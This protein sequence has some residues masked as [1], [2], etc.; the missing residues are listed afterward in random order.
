MRS[1]SLRSLKCMWLPRSL[2]KTR[3][4]P[5]VTI[6]R[7]LKPEK[8][9]VM[10][11]ALKSKNK[12]FSTNLLFFV[13]VTCEDTDWGGRFHEAPNLLWETVNVWCVAFC[14]QNVCIELT[15]QIVPNL[16]EENSK[17]R[18]DFLLQF[19]K[20]TYLF[21]QLVSV[22]KRSCCQSTA[23]RLLTDK[24]YSLKTNNRLS[25]HRFF[26]HSHH[27]SQLFWQI[28]NFRT[29]RYLPASL[30]LLLLWQTLPGIVRSGQRQCEPAEGWQEKR[31]H[32]RPS[33]IGLQHTKS[34]RN[35]MQTASKFLKWNGG[36][37]FATA[38]WTSI[39]DSFIY[40]LTA[41]SHPKKEQI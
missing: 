7:L 12:I 16:L 31:E 41:S 36:V 39:K 18:V 5:I 32:K 15:A 10:T 33:A 2:L 6:T 38:S 8:A 40:P 20:L 1:K 19:T 28:T 21:D 24:M 11:F 4:Y 34:R 17:D 35:D 22:L 25:W 9:I 30:W 26:I 13:F 3:S 23:A 37:A 29:M 27:A 14:A